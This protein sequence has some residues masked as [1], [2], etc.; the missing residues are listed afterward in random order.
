M[1]ILDVYIDVYPD[2]NRLRRDV[3]IPCN[4]SNGVVSCGV[5]LVRDRGERYMQARPINPAPERVPGPQVV[6][7]RE[8]LEPEA[9][10][11][12]TRRPGRSLGIRFGFC[13]FFRRRRPSMEW[14]RPVRRSDE[15]RREPVPGAPSP[16]PAFIPD[17]RGRP[18][19][20]ERPPPQ[21]PPYWATNNNDDDAD[22]DD[23]EIIAIE[24]EDG[25]S[26]PNYRE[27]RP[28]R[29]RRRSRAIVHN[30]SNTSSSPERVQPVRAGRGR[31][32]SPRRRN[33]P[34]REVNRARDL[35]RRH[36][37]EDS[38]RQN[39]RSRD[40]SRAE[41]PARDR[42]RAESESR[43]RDR[44]RE[45]L[46]EEANRADEAERIAREDDRERLRAREELHIERERRR[47]AVQRIAD[48]IVFERQQDL[49]QQR[50]MDRQPDTQR[51]E[52]SFVR[53]R[54]GRREPSVLPN[55]GGAEGTGDRILAEA[56]RARRQA[57][58]LRT[59]YVP[60]RERLGL[61]RR[62]TVSGG[63]RIVYD[64]DRRRRGRHYP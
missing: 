50:A 34:Q 18:W 37:V 36:D 45:T 27:I 48:D 61:G 40:R 22:Y 11:P 62:G 20:P 46:L 51:R 15:L 9:S 10:R 29:R 35:H 32:P 52:R 23:D 19:I 64:D 49:L 33:D 43:A 13:P 3:L 30:Y 54:P 38:G 24:G 56:A 42:R 4:R 25:E 31:T 39:G 57:A 6:P 1:C 63:E 5:N 26:E 41:T 21:L 60:L 28:R 53:E 47:R 7:V 44:E 14:R 8:V 12:T 16:P 58:T 55:R 17:P 2:Q 59:D